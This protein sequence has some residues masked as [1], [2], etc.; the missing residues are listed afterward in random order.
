MFKLN[1][2]CSLSLVSKFLEDKGWGEDDRTYKA[3]WTQRV[4]VQRGVKYIHRDVGSVWL[5]APLKSFYVVKKSS[6]LL[7]WCAE[8]RLSGRWWTFQSVNYRQQHLSVLPQLIHLL[9]S[10]QVGSNAVFH[11][12]FQLSVQDVFGGLFLACSGIKRPEILFCFL[13]FIMYR[14]YFIM[15]HYFH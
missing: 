8:R 11:W 12:Y 4:K 15:L 2:R 9:G 6:C 7:P 3:C 13:Q 10:L 5:I 14:L 1:R